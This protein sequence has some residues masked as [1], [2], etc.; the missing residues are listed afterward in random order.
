[1]WTNRIVIS[2]N[3]ALSVI[4]MF[5]ATHHKTS[6]KKYTIILLNT[7]L[8]QSVTRFYLV[9]LINYKSSNILKKI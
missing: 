5:V 8:I 3:T 6:L 7:K 1:M 2:Y 9:F 4:E